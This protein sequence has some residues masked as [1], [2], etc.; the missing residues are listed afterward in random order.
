[1]ASPGQP[2]AGWA[3]MV[4]RDGAYSPVLL[5]ALHLGTMA[6]RTTFTRRKPRPSAEG[7]VM[8]EAF[9][10]ATKRAKAKAFKVRTTIMVEKDGWLVMVN[11]A[12]RVVRKVKPV[13]AVVHS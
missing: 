5:G 9:T 8:S 10:E 11:K 7:L 3:R 13:N 2:G 12:G 4:G 6:K 1:M